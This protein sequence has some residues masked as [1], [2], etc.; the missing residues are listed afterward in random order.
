MPK[1]ILQILLKK[2]GHFKRY[3]HREKHHLSAFETV[4]MA[5]FVRHNTRPNV[6]SIFNQYK[7]TLMNTGILSFSFL[8]RQ[9]HIVG[10]KE[11]SECRMAAFKPDCFSPS[12]CLHLYEYWNSV[13]K[14]TNIPIKKRRHDCHSRLGAHFLSH[15]AL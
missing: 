9:Q 13:P 3:I 15:N 14:N 5:I 7:V 6:T 11:S 8:C 12:S 4:K 10:Q 2:K 1:Q